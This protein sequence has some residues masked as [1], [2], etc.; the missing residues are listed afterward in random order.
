MRTGADSLPAMSATSDAA[1]VRPNVR[2]LADLIPGDRVRDILL[3]VGA[4]AFV[5][6]LAQVT[7]PVPGSPVPIS[8]QTFGA[9]LAGAALGWQR[10]VAAMVLYLLL[11]GLGMPWFSDGQS[12]WSLPTLGYIVGFV[13]AAGL[14]GWMAGNG[15]DRRPLTTVLAMVIGSLVIYL[16]GIPW[17]MESTGMNLSTAL[18]L[19]F[20]PYLVGDLVKIVLAAAL[21]PAVWRIFDRAA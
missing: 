21:L 6:L 5:G 4:A 18:D 15:A 13:F 1:L 19:G 20:T 8:G 3:V 14:V 9:L 11:G 12:G 10:S 7:V 17:L 2:V 16:F